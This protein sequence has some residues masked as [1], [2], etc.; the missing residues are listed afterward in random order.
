LEDSSE[1]TLNGGDQTIVVFE[2]TP[3]IGEGD[4]TVT[5][6]ELSTT[7]TVLGPPSPT[8]A[9]FEYS[10][11]HVL[12]Q[13]ILLGE[14]VAASVTVKNVG[15]E[16]GDHTVDLTIDGQLGDSS[17]VTLNGGDQMIV[18]FEFSA[19]MEEGDHT[20]TVGE[21]STTLTIQRPPREIPV[22]TIVTVIIITIAVIIYLWQKELI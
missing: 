18:V 5:V 7:L 16:I 8:P 3:D 10:G 22:F 21:L 4:H 14:E 11:L 2:F 12:P 1:V 6:G 20:V 13:E 17:E 15:E 19:D 9:S